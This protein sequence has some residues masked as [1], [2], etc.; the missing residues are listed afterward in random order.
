METLIRKTNRTK[1]LD[2]KKEWEREYGKKRKVDVAEEHQITN[3]KSPGSLESILQR[4]LQPESSLI[5]KVIAATLHESSQSELPCWDDDDHSDL[6]HS[7]A[8]QICFFLGSVRDMYKSENR[9]LRRVCDA[10][11]IPLLRIRLGPVAEFSSKILTVLAY[12]DANNRLLPACLLLLMC[13]QETTPPSFAVVGTGTK[14]QNTSSN[15]SSGVILHFICQVP[16]PSD[17]VST[18]LEDRN[19]WIWC[20]VRCIVSSLWRSRLA[21]GKGNSSSSLQDSNMTGLKNRLSFLFQDGVVLTLDQMDL[22]T[23]MAE[24]H[25]AAPSEF[26]ILSMV[27]QKLDGSMKALHPKPV[28]ALVHDLFFDRETQTVQIPSMWIEFSGKTTTPHENCFYK[29]VPIAI[30]TAHTLNRQTKETSQLMAVAISLSLNGEG[31]NVAAPTYS[32]LLEIQKFCDESTADCSNVEGY[33]LVHVDC[34]DQEAVFITMLQ[35]LAYQERLVTLCKCI[36]EKSRKSC[37]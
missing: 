9:A 24:Q 11:A 19:R 28:S 21:S 37:R 20:M 12:H 34:I 10:N 17:C 2:I 3:E 36:D 4:I 22:V 30:N 25:Q 18:R 16:S 35:H 29:T 15:T 14:L 27:R 26:Q 8:V 31:C 13:S 1:L 23:D 6:R 7:N 33:N 32:S 5:E